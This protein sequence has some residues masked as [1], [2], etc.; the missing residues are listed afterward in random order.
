M[1]THHAGA[2]ILKL[3]PLSVLSDSSQP[4]DPR[5]KKSE[6]WEAVIRSEVRGWQIIRV[7]VSSPQCLVHKINSD[8]Y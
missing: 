1:H 2:Q 6:V 3:P 7:L 5:T 8:E 4:L